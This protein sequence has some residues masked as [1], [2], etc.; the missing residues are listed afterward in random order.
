MS[1]FTRGKPKAD[2][3]CRTSSILL[4]TL[5]LTA[6]A[7]VYFAARVSSLIH[8]NNELIQIPK[9]QRIE[10]PVRVEAFLLN[11]QCQGP[12]NVTVVEALPEKGP[13]SIQFPIMPKSMRVVGEG[14]LKLYNSGG[15]YVASLTELE[16]TCVPIYDWPAFVRGELHHGAPPRRVDPELQKKFFTGNDLSKPHTQI[17]YSAESSVYF[18]YQVCSL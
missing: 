14:E 2:K 16:G 4:A 10:T 9:P 3:R 13:A 6:L 11:D 18:G 17:V 5:A 7:M 1:R 15:E 8:M 12:N